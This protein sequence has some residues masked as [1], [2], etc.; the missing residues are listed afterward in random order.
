[1]QP[2]Q[3]AAPP[4]SG[5][6]DGTLAQG[7][8]P[9]GRLGSQLLGLRAR[10]PL[11]SRLRNA[12]SEQMACVFHRAQKTGDLG[13]HRSLWFLKWGGRLPAAARHVGEE[14]RSLWAP[15]HPEFSGGLAWAGLACC[16]PPAQ[17]PG[18]PA[19]ARKAKGGQTPSISSESES[20]A[21]LYLR[22]GPCGRDGE[23]F[24]LFCSWRQ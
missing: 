20:K 10:C 22:Q 23:R 12:K 11:L 24:V 3:E 17:S 14:M 15:P 9:A 13:A 16:S 1:M 21:E 19:A 5:P 6:E 7:H 4:C 8:G 2:P 18:N